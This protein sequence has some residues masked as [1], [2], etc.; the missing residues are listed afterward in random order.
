[1]PM[2]D[3]QFA[4]RT[5]RKSPVFALTA[6][7]TIA[8][9]I[10]AS[11]A[12]FSVTNAVLLRPLPYK[13]AD[14]LVV[15]GGDMRTRNIFDERV[16]YENYIDL[17]SGTSAV[18]ED[19]A[20]VATFRGILPRQ[21][22]T[23]EQIKN[24][25]VTTNFMRLLGAKIIAGRDFEQSDGQAAP[26]PDPAAPASAP[27]PPLPG[28]TIISY[29]YWQ[30]RFAGDP[31]IFGYP[32]RNA[33][34]N[35]P[36]VIG[37]LAPGFQLEFRESSNVN[38]DPD[39][40]TALRV[41]YDNRNRNG[42]YL[43]GIG[44]MKP[45]VTEDRVR[46]A[47]ELAAAGVRRN[48]PIYGT[49]NFHYHIESMKQHMVSEVRPA[50]LALMGAV[51]FLLLI[52]CANVAN[53]LLVRMSQRERELAVRT[54]LG[55]SRWRLVRQMLCESVLLGG[56]GTLLGVGIAYAGI[57][58]LIA[59]SPANLPRLEG[60]A[61]DRSVLLFSIVAGLGAAAIF[62]IAPALRASRPDVMETL[63][64]GGRNAGLAGGGFRNAVAVAEVALSFVLLIG[65]GLMV[66][67][68]IAVQH[69]E[70]GIDPNRL[71]T[72]QLLGGRG[73]LK[74]EE[75]KA[76]VLE[77][78][79]ALQGIGGV[80][81]VTAAALV[82]LAGGYSTI[83]WGKEDALADPSRFQAADVQ[84]VQPKFF[85]TM[86]TPL[87]AGRTF[88]QAD[89][90]P[91]RKYVVVDTLL[92]GKA[93]PHES[94]VGRRILIRVRT[95]EPEWVEIIGVVAHQR[96]TSLSEPGHEQVY[97]TD[98]FLDFNVTNRWILRT[99]GDPARVAPAV[100]AAIHKLDATLLITEMWPMSVWVNRAQ[101]GT[102]FSLVLISVFAGIAAILANVGLYGVLSTFVRQRT[103]EIGLRMALGAAPA[104]IFGLVVGHGLVLSAT[105]IGI[106]IL[107]A[108]VLTRMMSTMLIGVRGTDPVT[109]LTMIGLFFMIAVVSCW[110]PAR[111]AAGLAPTVALRE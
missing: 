97:V 99:A 12:I 57:R 33:G 93:Y 80:E 71:L 42:Y 100:R 81:S 87:I 74:P 18:L 65:S 111:R 105:G 23:P 61:I 103:A 66:R 75:R 49:G 88:T 98:G 29:E 110:I 46:E 94:A 41:N 27:P 109:F 67:S 89:N 43:R 107:A 106:G 28:M 92:A 51:A 83:R 63:R 48:F 79:T 24:A 40:F 13:D 32:I 72:F 34:P 44:R 64:G 69:V 4:L 90:A 31:S 70:L 52:A 3:F 53:L 17:K 35:A 62:G 84:T 54:A 1:M 15:A 45:G 47:G 16:S 58:E 11:T 38:R 9:G 8:L 39:L 78:Q 37:A 25:F 85:E 50:I 82:P 14:R 73:G 108:A 19:M 86:R 102:R 91:D 68:F 21:D 30:R 96:A 56:A 26:P 104:N 59:I 10:G 22:G 7:V 95:P 77:I 6:I 36:V 55:G 20:A 60:V 2:K 101:A 76:R 5:L